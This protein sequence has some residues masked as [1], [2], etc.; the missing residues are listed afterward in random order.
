MEE[1]KETIDVRFNDFPNIGFIT[2]K[3]PHNVLEPILSEVSKMQVD[4]E[5]NIKYWEEWAP[6]MGGSG[7]YK[8]GVQ[9]QPLYKQEHS[10]K[11]NK[12]YNYARRR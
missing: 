3:L 6:G 1:N 2:A 10:I 12:F 7:F 11:L 9:I 8:S 4:F 5:D